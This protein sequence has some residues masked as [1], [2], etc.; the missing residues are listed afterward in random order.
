MLVAL[1]VVPIVI[2]AAGAPGQGA[3]AKPAQQV[4]PIPHTQAG[5]ITSL[6]VEGSQRIEPETV[7]SYTKLR[8]GQAFTNE[9]L[10]QA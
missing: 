2:A 9:T 7:L 4:S 8:T 5:R 10:D 3:A 6:R 1:A